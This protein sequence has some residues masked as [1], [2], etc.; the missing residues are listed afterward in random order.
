MNEYVRYSCFNL[1]VIGQWSIHSRVWAANHTLIDHTGL[2]L[3]GGWF[4]C[5]HF[6]AYLH[7][8]FKHAGLGTYLSVCTVR[9]QLLLTN[10]DRTESDRVSGGCLHHWPVA[11]HYL[12]V[13]V[14]P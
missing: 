13:R 7:L 11:A 8:R 2:D 12:S 6:C 4:V 10:G 3:S 9:V 14:T 5:T 1:Y